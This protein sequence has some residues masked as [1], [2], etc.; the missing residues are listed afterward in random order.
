MGLLKA[1]GSVKTRWWAILAVAAIV[2]AVILSAGPDKKA[3]LP[4]IDFDPETSP[5]MFTDSVETLISDSGYVRYKIIAPVWYVYGEAKEPNWKF[6]EGMYME[7]YDDTFAITTTAVCDSAV[8]LQ[9]RRLWEFVGNVRMINRDGDRFMT[10]HMYWDTYTH[11]LRSD[12]FMHIEQPARVIEGYGFETDEQLRDY[13]VR[14]PTM[15]IPVSQFEDRADKDPS[16]SSS[17]SP[18]NLYDPD[19]RSRRPSPIR[20]SERSS[21]IY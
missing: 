18:D 5:T 3:K 6:S 13:I 15:I 21:S 14:R 19:Y 8:Y 9:D 4:D 20:A 7:M 10:Q 1:I 2:V 16:S 17:P 11:K 12:S